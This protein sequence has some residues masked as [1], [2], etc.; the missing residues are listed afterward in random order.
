ME[1]QLGKYFFLVK[2]GRAK[3]VRGVKLTEYGGHEIG[4]EDIEVLGL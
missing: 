3:D 1:G 4:K 2:T